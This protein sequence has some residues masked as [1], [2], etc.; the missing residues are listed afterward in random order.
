LRYDAHCRNIAIPWNITITGLVGNGVMI[1]V[2]FS[3]KVTPTSSLTPITTANPSPNANHDLTP[4]PTVAQTP[5]IT[6][7]AVS[8]HSRYSHNHPGMTTPILT[9]VVVQL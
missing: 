7:T 1:E 4:T 5:T 6:T 3:V 8:D 2:R 9:V